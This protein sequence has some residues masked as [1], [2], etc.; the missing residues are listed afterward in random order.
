MCN[1]HPLWYRITMLISIIMPAY[2]AG[3]TICESIESV[4]AQTHPRWE[5]LVVDDQSTDHTPALVQSYIMKEPR[6][7][8]LTCPQNQGTAATR[9]L[10]AAHASGTYLAFL[11]AD[12]LWDKTK[13]AQQLRFMQKNNAAISYTSTAYINEA[14]Q[15]ADYILPAE[16]KLSY[17][18]L[19]RKNIMSCSSVMVL[20][21]AFIPFPAGFVHEDYVSWLKIVR[22][23]GNAYGLNQPLLLYRLG[24]HTKSSNRLKSA[25]MNWNAYRAVGYNPLT[26]TFFMLRYAIH[27]ITKRIR[28]NF[29]K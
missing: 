26:A 21:G 3:A 12:D 27:S 9:N 24:A 6:I 10:G 2:N 5:L 22:L 17:K 16:E 25:R 8:L 15:M 13:L 11:D 28:I 23:H 4:I 14:G 1:N 18:T 19:L 20:R 7:K 29:A